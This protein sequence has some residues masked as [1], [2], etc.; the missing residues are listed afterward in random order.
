MANASEV[1]ICSGALV[2]LGLQPIISLADANAQA[3]ACNQVYAT[4]RDALL[5]MHPWKFATRYVTLTPDVDA[6]PFDF[7][8]Q[9]TLPSDYLK[10]QHESADPY[11]QWRLVGNKIF[12]N[13]N[14]F[15]LVYTARVT[16]P[17]QF[18]SLFVEALED[19]IAMILALPLTRQSKV[20]DSRA[21]QFAVSMSE[22]RCATLQESTV[23]SDTFEA[24]AWTNSRL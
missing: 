1:S 20:Y 18:D 7:D 21:A 9:F 10:L 14:V 4:Q 15:E 17:T 13:D 11:Y 16:D 6:P 2:K 23:A 12:A 24:T 5:R 3:R 22:A 8:Y 19:K